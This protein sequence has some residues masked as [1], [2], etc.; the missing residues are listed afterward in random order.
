M[1]LPSP[2]RLGSGFPLFYGR[3]KPPP[4]ITPPSISQ[5]Y[6]SSNLKSMSRM[7]DS[8]NRSRGFGNETIPQPR[9]SGIQAK[10]DASRLTL[11][12]T[13]GQPKM[14][15]SPSRIL[16]QREQSGK[17]TACGIQTHKVHKINGTPFMMPLTEAGRV[18]NGICLICNVSKLQPKGPE[19]SN[20]LHRSEARH[21]DSPLSH[22]LSQEDVSEN[23]NQTPGYLSVKIKLDSCESIA[24]PL[25]DTHVQYK[26]D[27]ISNKKSSASSSLRV[28][29]DPTESQPSKLYHSHTQ[30]SIS[31]SLS[32]EWTKSHKS[33]APLGI[34]A[35]VDPMKSTYSRLTEKE[36]PER[37]PL[38]S[39]SKEDT[40]SSK[41]FTDS[42]V[43]EVALNP[44]ESIVSHQLN[45]TQLQ[46]S[47][48]PSPSKEEPTL[49]SVSPATS[50][51]NVKLDSIGSNTSRTIEGQAQH[52]L[53]YSHS[54]GGVTENNKQSSPRFVSLDR[55]KEFIR[56][57][58]LEQNFK[59]KPEPL[60]S[61]TRSAKSTRR[62][63]KPGEGTQ[64]ELNRI[65]KKNTSLS[66][67]MRN[68]M[69]VAAVLTRKMDKLGS[70][71]KFLGA[72]GKL[73]PDLRFNFG[74][75]S[76]M[77]QCGVCRQRVQGAYYC[78][79]K[80]C[81]LEV[82]DYDSAANSAEC[83]KD[84]FR[85]SIEELEELQTQ[86][87]GGP[88]RGLHKAEKSQMLMSNHGREWS[89]DHLHED[90]LLH[91][92]SFIPTLTTLVLFCS[93]SKRANDLLKNG[94]H[95]ED[96]YRGLFLKKFGY[97]G[98]RGN[99]DMNM[100]WKDRWEMV[101]CLKR[102]M[103][104]HP[105]FD[106]STLPISRSSLRRTVG[107]LSAQDE[108]DAII[109]DNPEYASPDREMCNGYFGLQV[110]HLPPPPNA[111]K[112]WQP[113]VLLHGD[114]NGIKIFN[115]LDDAIRKPLEGEDELNARFVSLGDDEH[116]GQVLSIIHCDF[117]LAS[118]WTATDGSAVSPPCCFVGYASG[119]VAAV[120]AT[121]SDE[122]QQYNFTISSQSHAHDFEVTCFS[123][124]QITKNTTLL[125]SACCGG[126]IRFYPNALNKQYFDLQCDLAFTN[127]YGCGIFS[128]ASTVIESKDNR[129]FTLLCTGDRDGK[130]RLWLVGS[131]VLSKRNFRHLGHY[132]SST[133]TG[134]GF[135]LVTRAKFINDD[136]LVTGTNQG[137]VRIWR[138]EIKNISGRCIGK[139]P[140]PKLTLK[141]DLMGQHSGSVEVCTNVGDVLLTSGGDDGSIVGWDTYSGIKLCTLKCHRGKELVHPD[142]GDRTV[143]RSSVVDVVM[144][145]VDGRLVSLCR[146]GVL[147]EWKF[148]PSVK[149]A[150]SHT[151]DREMAV[152]DLG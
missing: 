31:S 149:R 144:N 76:N 123:F 74:K 103:N 4:Q 6:I 56:Q 72:N 24:S 68:S 102:S 100:T 82:T 42:F 119:R 128:M 18:L 54:K 116:G 80:Q 132:N 124:V 114:F 106:V 78:R 23:F 112:N 22:S 140:L 141:N 131:E 30:Q 148:G 133:Q 38:S 121:L 91:V 48:A 97:Q 105:N 8:S 60:L 14:A 93:T 52:L 81:H 101:H 57:K 1:N 120:S 65:M 19:E 142:T 5:L 139:G 47:F 130:I 115:S 75:Y 95:S 126:S 67:D 37:S 77:K 33:S 147:A 59:R 44:T 145:R 45:E 13:S 32:M 99:Y 94:T 84:L 109:Y 92:A 85:M 134:T 108:E 10:A 3:I 122:S 98:S 107:V 15:M 104:R 53:S 21:P 152:I 20:A 89:L 135:H 73:Y 64:M 138:L 79:L 50:G 129:T 66:E 43:L 86:W 110:L 46:Q 41:K 35:G 51:L 26:E 111:P 58:S 151:K 70:N 137:D 125:F 62:Q 2:P 49:K 11:K 16:K 71:E 27:V 25:L 36:Q 34:K 29:L 136:L 90:L 39:A 40:A 63:Q 9:D 150:Q 146:D 87:I 96:L 143:V 88:K 113:P 55:A 17:C 118:I 61:S 117:D 69:F 127:F 12:R 83:L 28:K 7:G